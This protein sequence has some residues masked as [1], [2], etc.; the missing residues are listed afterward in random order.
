M[1]IYQM[2]HQQYQRSIF[3][4]SCDRSPE[5]ADNIR[6]AIQDFMRNHAPSGSGIDAG[7]QFEFDRS[8][9]T[10]LV[11]STAFH[12]MNE[13]GSYDGWTHH[14]LRVRPAFDGITMTI[15][16]PNR[17]DI[18]DYLHDLYHDWLNRQV[19]ANVPGHSNCENFCIEDAIKITVEN[20]P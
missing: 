19:L 12:H 7:T 6:K 11:F 13:H 3:F 4:D 2:L 14:T 17:N 9:D 1:K 15:S 5:R 8:S 20:Q 16:G 10:L 18:R